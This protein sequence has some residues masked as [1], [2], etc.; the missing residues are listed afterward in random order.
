MKQKNELE[1]LIE[2]ESTFICKKYNHDCIY[3]FIL[4]E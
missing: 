4:K 2:R 1:A 3:N